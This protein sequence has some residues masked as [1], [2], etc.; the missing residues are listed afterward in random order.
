MVRDR[1]EDAPAGRA[2]ALPFEFVLDALGPVDPVT[3]PMFGC[4]AVYVGEKIVM[5]LR[6][7]G[8]ADSGVWIATT[9]EHH[10]ALRPV[11]PSMRS[12]GVLGDGV[13]GWQNLPDDSDDF[14]EAA[15]RAC[16]LVRARDPRIGKVPKKKKPAAP[17]VTAA[18]AAK[19]TAAKKPTV[20]TTTA[21][22]P[23]ARSATKPARSR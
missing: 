1:F 20:K 19:K 14:E 10:D 12:V 7:K 17:K 4:T 13:T 8:D 23:S 15:L 9:A 21:K 3:K 18:T 2:K 22:K 6:D 16:A 11:L 5:I